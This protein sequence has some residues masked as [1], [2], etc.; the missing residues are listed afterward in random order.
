LKWPI[1]LRGSRELL[2]DDLE[3]YFDNWMHLPSN[4]PPL[5]YPYLFAF[6]GKPWLTQKWSRRYTT[7]DVLIQPNADTDDYIKFSSDGTNLTQSTV[8]S[9]NL[10]IS[11]TGSLTLTPTSTLTANS[12]GDMTLDSS[13]DIILDADGADWFLKDNGTTIATFT[14]TATNDLTLDVAGDNFLSPDSL[15]FGGASQSCTAP[16]L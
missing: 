8:G 5:A 15:N 6:F 1:A 2:S 11:P 3:Y 12:T 9:S 14:N 4:E 16:R 10:T 7:G 13:T